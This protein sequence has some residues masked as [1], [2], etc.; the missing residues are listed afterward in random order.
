MMGRGRGGRWVHDLGA[1][2][3]IASALAAAGGAEA[4]AP[5]PPPASGRAASPGLLAPVAARWTGDLDGMGRRR[6]VRVLVTHSKTFYFVDR[7]RQRGAT[8]DTLTAFEADLNRGLGRRQLKVRVVF[9]PV[10]R[11][12]LLPALREGRGDLA[13]ANLTV[14]PERRRVVDFSQ[15][16]L[17]GV[18]EVPVSGPGLPA[19]AGVADLAGREVFVRRSSSYHESLVRASQELVQAGRGPIRIRLAPESLE[20]EDLLEMVN[21]GLVKLV[22]VDSH[23]AEFWAQIFPRLRLH[24]EAAVRTGGEIAWAFRP[25]SPRLRAAVNRFVAG[26]RE[27]TAFGNEVFRRYLRSTRFVKGALE[28]D[29]LRRYEE[30]V[31]LFRRYGDRFRFD[32]LLLAAQ[33]YQESQLDQRRRS[34]VGAIGVMQVMPATGREMKVGDVRQLEPN[35][36]AGAKYLRLMVDEFFED[37][38]SGDL[39][40]TLFAFASY[41]AGPARVVRWRREAAQAGLNPNVWFDHVE[42]VAARRIGLEPIQY[43]SNIHKYYVAYHLL[44]EERAERARALS[45]LRSAL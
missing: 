33:G 24:P 7:G 27:G 11:E 40:R 39:D 4:A 35:I 3:L 37:P 29:E 13:V 8:Y 9:V 38:R 14:T 2:S 23:K 43:V 25:G 6:I 19:M 5:G 44:E 22:V 1:V 30:T 28:P 16:L 36:H 34:R 26:H 20:D 42:R 17:T 10:S 21:A 12:D 15:P 41:N 18:S 31:D 32:Y 45:A